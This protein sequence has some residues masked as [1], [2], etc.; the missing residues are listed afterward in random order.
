VIELASFRL[1][2]MTLAIKDPC[3]EIK[4]NISI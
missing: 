4:N 3:L 2:T 1:A